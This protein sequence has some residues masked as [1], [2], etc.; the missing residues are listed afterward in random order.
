MLVLDDLPCGKQQ[1]TEAEKAAGT[2]ETV[3][4]AAIRI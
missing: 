1:L 4:L 2:E 3:L